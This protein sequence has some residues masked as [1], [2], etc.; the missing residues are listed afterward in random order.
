MKVITMRWQGPHKTL[1]ATG[2]TIKDRPPW[3]PGSWQVCDG[4]RLIPRRQQFDARGC[5][6]VADERGV[7]PAGANLF[8]PFL[9]GGCDQPHLHPGARRASSDSSSWSRSLRPWL[10][11]RRRMPTSPVAIS[12]ATCRVLSA[13]DRTLRASGSSRSPA[14]VSRTRRDV[15]SNSCTPSSR[16]IR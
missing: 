1:R 14:A 16:S 2:K 11:P 13:A 12:A 15:R 4:K 7:Q 9:A 3:W 5:T 10:V 8:Q 6:G